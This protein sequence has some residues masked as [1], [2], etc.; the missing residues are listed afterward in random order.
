[1]TSSLTT[2]F[3]SKF[4]AV[5]R[6]HSNVIVHVNRS[7]EE[8]SKDKNRSS[9]ISKSEDSSRFVLSTKATHIRMSRLSCPADKRVVSV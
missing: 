8:I 6:I 7:T 5:D 2:G 3:R 1:M 9:V 4:A